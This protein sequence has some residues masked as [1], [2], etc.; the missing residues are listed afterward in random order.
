MA[1]HKYTK[2]QL[3]E[4]DDKYR[5]MRDEFMYPEMVGSGGAEAFLHIIFSI[6]MVSVLI[7]AIF[8]LV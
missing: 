1:Q 7:Y 8:R 5:R 2:K 4:Q 3:K 6:F